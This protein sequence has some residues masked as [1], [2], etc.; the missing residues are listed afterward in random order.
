MTGLR[1]PTSTTSMRLWPQPTRPAPQALLSA[2]AARRGQ[3]GS[4]PGPSP[5]GR[6]RQGGRGMERLSGKVAVIS[7]GAR[8]QGAAEVRLF[9]AEGARVVFGDVLD[10]R[11]KALADELGDDAV[12]VHHDVRQE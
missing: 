2:P 4:V 3:G 9:V 12:Y 5:P 10:D 6:R 8:G 7:G 1:Q 11:G